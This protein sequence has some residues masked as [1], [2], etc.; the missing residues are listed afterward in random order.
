MGLRRGGRAPPTPGRGRRP[1]G[2]G[3]RLALAGEWAGWAWGEDG[4]QSHQG[5]EAAAGELFPRGGA[6]A[7]GAGWGQPFWEGTLPGRSRAAWGWVPRDGSRWG[8]ELVGLRGTG[9][10]VGP[11]FY[12]GGGA[13]GPGPPRFG[14]GTGALPGK[15]RLGPFAGQLIF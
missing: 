1:L 6:V 8:T 13:A 14:G 11:G 15:G 12:G 9:G 3:F 4:P 5:E 10:A 7:W 2:G